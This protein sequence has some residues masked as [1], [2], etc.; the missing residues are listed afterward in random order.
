VF[1]SYYLFLQLHSVV[2][3]H[4]TYPAFRAWWWAIIII[5]IAYIFTVE[6]AIVSDRISKIGRYLTRLWKE[7]LRLSF[8]TILYILRLCNGERIS[9][10]KPGRH[11]RHPGNNN[12]IVFYTYGVSCSRNWLID[13]LL[14]MINLYSSSQIWSACQ[15][16]SGQSI[17]AIDYK[18]YVSGFDK[19]SKVKIKKYMYSPTLHGID[20]T[21]RRLN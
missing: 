2:K 14:C 16:T 15:R 5:I 10:V 19:N 13:S 20:F 17:L 9:G 1:L 21:Y 12:S 7:A 11:E 8:W 3:R 6:C 4:L 18:G